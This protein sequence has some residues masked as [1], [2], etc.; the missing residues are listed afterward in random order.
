MA[1]NVPQQQPQKMIPEAERIIP[2]HLRNPKD[3]RS[4][5]PLPPMQTIAPT[6][7]DG[8]KP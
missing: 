4:R 8:A 5:Q 2:P 6:L 3:T 1:L 7:F